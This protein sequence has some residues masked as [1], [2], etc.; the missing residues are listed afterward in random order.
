MNT[1]GSRNRYKLKE[2]MENVQTK[3]TYVGIINELVFFIIACLALLR[4]SW[5]NNFRDHFYSI[6][7]AVLAKYCMNAT[8][9]ENRYEL[10]VDLETENLTQ[11]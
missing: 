4:N 11:K 3:N 8:G 7:F 2:N 10:K 5:K 9:I 1:V 6:T